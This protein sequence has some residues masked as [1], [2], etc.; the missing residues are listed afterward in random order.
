LQSAT[1]RNAIPAE[2]GFQLGP[3][4]LNGEGR[5]STMRLVPTLKP[6]QPAQM[7]SAFEI[8]GVALIPNETR[9]RV[10]LTPAGTTP[11]TMELFAHL[12]LNA[13]ELTPSFQVAQLILNWSTNAV[14]VTLNP[15]APEQT[16]AKFELRVLKL[17]DA[18][19]IAEL[20]LHP[21]K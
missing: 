10:Q 9:A 1:T 3:V 8:G 13:V 20:L 16:A 11:M 14:R 5:I 6:F 18:G 7:R 19:R 15:K 21:T 4:K 2:L 12:E 17:D